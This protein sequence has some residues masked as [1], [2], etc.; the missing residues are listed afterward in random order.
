MKTTAYFYYDIISPFSYFFIKSIRR[1]E[2]KLDLMARPIFL[3]GL[4]RLQNNRGPAEVAEKRIYTYQYCVWRAKQLG[5]PFRIPSRHPFASAPAQRLLLQMDASLGVVE[6]AF[7]FVWAKGNDPETHWSEFC[8]ATGLSAQTPK[9]T[10][11]AIKQALTDATQNACDAGV[12]GVPSIKINERVFWGSESID[13]ILEYL[14][15]PD[16]FKASEYTQILNVTNP[17]LG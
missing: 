13:W 2:D 6:S 1:L 16:M 3:P 8:V 11:P 9:P 17:L 7:D 5:L 4:L 14:Q 12:F 10:D 15:N